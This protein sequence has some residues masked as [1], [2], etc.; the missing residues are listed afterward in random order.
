MNDTYSLNITVRKENKILLEEV[1]TIHAWKVSDLVEA[2]NE[3]GFKVQG[4]YS[5]NMEQ[6]KVTDWKFLVVAIK[7]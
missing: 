6:L 5:Q 7:E 4:I 2:L 3:T 1:H